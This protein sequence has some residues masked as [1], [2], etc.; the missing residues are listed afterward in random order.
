[1]LGGRHLAVLPWP[2]RDL[3]QVRGMI[4]R[5][6]LDGSQVCLDGILDVLERFFFRGALGPAAR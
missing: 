4:H 5:Q 3:N 6:F 1:M 2:H